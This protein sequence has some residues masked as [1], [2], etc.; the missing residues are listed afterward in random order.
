MGG[1]TKMI[2][3]GWVLLLG[4]LFWFFQDLG[5][6]EANP[7]RNMVVSSS[8]EVVLARARDG[9]YYAEG[10]INGKPVKFLLDTGASQIALSPKLANQIGLTLGATLTLQTA[11][12][13]STGYRTRL[14]RVRLGSIEMLDLAGI[15]AE[16]MNDETVLL[17]M[18]FL[19]RLEIIQRGEHMTL[20]PPLAKNH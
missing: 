14:A 10:E 6:R 11:A 16:G 3:V 20:R 4:A 1:N 9:H 18:N 12:G 5:E 7:N 17:G 19:R 15:V 13:P 2:V 8:S